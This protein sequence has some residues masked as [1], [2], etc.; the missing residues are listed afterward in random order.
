MQI[1]RHIAEQEQ[2]HFYLVSETQPGA[3]ENALIVFISQ[4]RLVSNYHFV[5]TPHRK[6]CLGWCSAY[7]CGKASRT[8]RECWVFGGGFET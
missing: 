6:A 7:T 8:G 4:D 2:K 5:Y 3:H 1:L